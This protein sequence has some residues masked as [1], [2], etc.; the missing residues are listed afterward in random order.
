MK[1]LAAG[2][3]FRTRTKGQG[4][5]SV[6]PPRLA[7]DAKA[8]SNKFAGRVGTGFS[9]KLLASLYNKI[10]KIRQPPCP[11]INLPEKTAA[12]RHRGKG[13]SAGVNGVERAPS[14]K[15]PSAG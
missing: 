13:C 9:D 8:R 3:C 4:R 6:T 15:R 2:G 14:N 5:Q 7:I 11:F 10:Q 1:N 12:D